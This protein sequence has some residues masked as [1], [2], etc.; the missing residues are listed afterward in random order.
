M[1]LEVDEDWLLESLSWM[2]N[3]DKEILTFKSLFIYGILHNQ[4][5][6]LRKYACPSN[7]L[8]VLL[9]APSS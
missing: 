4:N 1:R 6:L 8:G 3:L 5:N 9:M 7:L 2:E